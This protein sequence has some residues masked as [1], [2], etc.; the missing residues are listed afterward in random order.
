LARRIVP[1]LSVGERR[2]ARA[3]DPE[4]ATPGEVGVARDLHDGVAN[5]RRGQRRAA[6]KRLDGSALAACVGVDE[7]A[8]DAALGCD[9]GEQGDEPE[10]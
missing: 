3:V 7:W 5:R 1:R 9:R 10:P 2:E 6:E 4:C 8:A